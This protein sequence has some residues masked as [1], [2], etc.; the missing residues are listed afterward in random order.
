MNKLMLLALTLSLV[1][2]A[3]MA[4]FGPSAA[5]PGTIMT[6]TTYPGMVYGSTNY[7]F[8]TADFKIKGPVTVEA[9]SS[10]I[11]GIISSGDSGYGKLFQEAKDKM[12]ADDVIC[13][14]VDTFHYNILGIIAKVKTKMHGVAVEWTNK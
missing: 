9:E 3:G 2:C 11:L 8:T 14:K 1:G 7:N 6:S 12:Q 13:V 4:G 10:S 5:H